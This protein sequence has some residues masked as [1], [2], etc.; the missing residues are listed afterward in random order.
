MT[1]YIK[2]TVKTVGQVYSW[3][4]INEIFGNSGIESNYD[5]YPYNN[6]IYYEIGPLEDAKNSWVCEAY[7]TAKAANPS[8]KMFYNDDMISSSAGKY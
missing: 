2:N 7:K 1:D 5:H 3:D 6:S 4:V 8:I